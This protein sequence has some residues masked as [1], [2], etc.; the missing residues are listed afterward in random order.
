MKDAEMF[1]ELMKKTGLPRQTVEAAVEAAI[2]ETVEKRLGAYDCDVNLKERTAVGV[3][4]VPQDIS[5]Q[6]ALFFNTAVVGHDIV[7]V[8]FDLAS[9]PAQMARHSSEILRRLLCDMEASARYTEWQAKRGTTINGVVIEKARD[10]VRL[11]L[12]G[13]VGRLLKAEWV[14]TEAKSRYTQGKPLVVYVLRVK[15]RGS[16]VAVFVS[17]QTRNLPARLLKQRISWHKFLCVYRK[18]GDKSVVFTD[19]FIADNTLRAA[20]KNV[21]EEL[22]EKLKLKSLKKAHQKGSPCAAKVP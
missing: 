21:Q 17:R 12:G 15:R 4:R 8:K 9:F 1:E 2:A 22:G 20:R 10:V 11:D 16:K 6:E 3:F 18:A 7:T 14:P 19:C 5:L 13:Q